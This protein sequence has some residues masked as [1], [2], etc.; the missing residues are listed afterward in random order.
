M[1][2]IK[3]LAL[4]LAL[5]SMFAGST[6]A[7]ETSTPPCAQP[8][9][10]ETSTPPC[11]GGHATSDSSTSTFTGAAINTADDV[12]NPPELQLIEKGIKRIKD[13]KLYVLSTT[14]GTRGHGTHSMPAIW[15]GWLAE[16]LENS[17]GPK[18]KIQAHLSENLQDAAL[19]SQR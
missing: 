5:V 16:L 10:G 13:A 7:G 4:A 6:F 9:P 11:D 17:G 12:I 8:L 3:K 18:R 2:Q 1:K 19:S 15:Q 14:F